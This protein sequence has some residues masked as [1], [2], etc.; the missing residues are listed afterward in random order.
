MEN[1]QLFVLLEVVQ[2]VQRQGRDKM[3]DQGQASGQMPVAL[4]LI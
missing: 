4:V 2:H 1:M 3:M